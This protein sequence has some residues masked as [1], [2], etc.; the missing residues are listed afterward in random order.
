M[1]KISIE[2]HSGT[3]RFAVAIKA[4]SVQQALI[5]HGYNS[6]RRER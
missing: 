6:K 5:H 4:Q 3:A 2:V 1:V